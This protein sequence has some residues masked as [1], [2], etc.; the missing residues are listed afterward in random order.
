MEHPFRFEFFRG[1]APEHEV[2][3]PRLASRAGPPRSRSSCA[4][5]PSL[6]RSPRWPVARAGLE[7][8][9]VATNGRSERAWRKR[10]GA[11]RLRDRAAEAWPDGGSG[12]TTSGLDADARIRAGS[13]DERTG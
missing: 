12:R 8:N 4:R 5:A 13:A 10:M 11:R 2:A 9:G 1:S 7:G 6:P 3:G